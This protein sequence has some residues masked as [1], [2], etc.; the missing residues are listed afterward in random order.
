MFKTP[1]ISKDRQDRDGEGAA[2]RG[3]G[4]DERLI[5]QQDDYYDDVDGESAELE[6]LPVPARGP[7]THAGWF[8][9]MLT[10]AAGISGLLFGCESPSG[11][12]PLS[13]WATV[14]LCETNC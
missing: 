8:I 7:D 9:W 6:P 12:V 3:S 10:F 2:P 5:L 11:A 4:D 1:L 13:G 14:V